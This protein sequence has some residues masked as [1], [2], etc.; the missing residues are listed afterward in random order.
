MLPLR[1]PSLG[2]SR[3]LIIHYLC[4]QPVGSIVSICIFSKE[5]EGSS[6]VGSGISVPITFELDRIIRVSFGCAVVN[7][8]S[9]ILLIIVQEQLPYLYVIVYVSNCS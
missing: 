7:F 8:T 6:L 4:S 5:D 2:R 3:N 9:W 1:L